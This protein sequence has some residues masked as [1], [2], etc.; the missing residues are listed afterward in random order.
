M[1]DSTTPPT[2]KDFL[3]VATYF[4][5]SLVLAAYVIGWWGGVNPLAN[6]RLEWYSLLWGLAGTLPLYLLFLLSYHVP[7]GRLHAIKRFLIDRLGPY[8]DACHWTQLLYL[9]LLAGL[10]EEILFRGLLQPLLEN[11]WGYSVGIV[12]SNILFA[13]AHFIT[14][15]YAV[16]AGLTGLYLG[17]SLDFG[18]E[19]NLLTPIVIHSVY[20]F[21]AFLAVAKTYR[22]ER[23]MLC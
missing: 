11:H 19:R 3:K 5:G 12:G 7:L 9:G 22:L 18:G 2:P 1:F 17:L 16:L 13:L 10:T 21:L 15:L 23:G 6:L 20:D 14:P 8:L 4:E